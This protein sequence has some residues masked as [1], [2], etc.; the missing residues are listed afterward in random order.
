MAKVE[1]TKCK[2]GA[3]ELIC[4]DC[5]KKEVNLIVKRLDD[6][7]MNITKLEAKVKKMTDF[8]AAFDQLTKIKEKL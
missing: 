2:A 4:F 1:C 6:E 5:H 8:I 7:L 3:E